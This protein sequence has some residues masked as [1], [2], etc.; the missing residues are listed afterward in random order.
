MNPLRTYLAAEGVTQVRFAEMIGVQQ[1]MVSRL[2]KGKARPSLE[3]AVA[4][5]RATGG[6]VPAATWVPE[7]GLDGAPAPETEAAP[8]SQVAASEPP[9]E[10]RS[11]AGG[12]SERGAA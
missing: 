3:T 10:R 1:S 8:D 2:L 11:P 6:A 12:V 5:E 4:I 7:T 9:A